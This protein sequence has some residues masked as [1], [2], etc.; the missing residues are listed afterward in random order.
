MV[1]TVSSFDNEY[2]VWVKLDNVSA[3]GTAS[4]Y[5]YFTTLYL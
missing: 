1:K 2:S 4:I 3:K 5:R